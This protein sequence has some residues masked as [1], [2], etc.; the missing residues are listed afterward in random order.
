MPTAPLSIT[1]GPIDVAAI[2]RLVDDCEQQGVQTRI[3]PDLFQMSLNRVD[4]A[5]PAE[6]IQRIEA[7]GAPLLGVLSN[8]RVENIGMEGRYGYGYGSNGYGG[9]AGEAALNPGTAYAYYRDGEAV[10]ARRS[11]LT[12]LLPN[13][14]NRRRWGR[15][16][17]S[18]ID[19]R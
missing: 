11:G 7:A 18:W 17:R 15:R 1:S 13:P 8:S 12:A 5:L 14:A 6:A 19:G 10:A 9:S 16:L 2:V 4:R 3:V